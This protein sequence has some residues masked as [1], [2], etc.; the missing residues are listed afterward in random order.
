MDLNGLLNR[1]AR[2]LARSA[3]DA[4]VDHVA[5]RGKP[6]AAMTPDERARARKGQDLARR[7]KEISKVARRLWR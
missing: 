4:G 2:M 7:A 1:L 3:V 6:R 5:R